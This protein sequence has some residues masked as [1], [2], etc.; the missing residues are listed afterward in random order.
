M[1]EFNMELIKEN[2]IEITKSIAEENGNYDADATK[3]CLFAMYQQIEQW[4]FSELDDFFEEGLGENKTILYDELWGVTVGYALIERYNLS[5][6]EYRNW[7]DKQEDKYFLLKLIGED[8]EKE[9]QLEACEDWQ[10]ILESLDS[11]KVLMNYTDIET[12][13]TLFGKPIILSEEAKSIADLFNELEGIKEYA[14]SILENGISKRCADYKQCSKN[15]VRVLEDSVGAAWIKCKKYLNQKKQPEEKIEYLKKQYFEKIEQIYSI[16]D[17][18]DNALNQLSEISGGKLENIVLEDKKRR[19]RTFAGGGLGIY[20][21]IAGMVGASVLNK[22]NDAWADACTRYSGKQLTEYL[23]G[24]AEEIY[25]GEET[26]KI[27]KEV[28]EASC[29]ELEMLCIDE[30]YPDSIENQEMADDMIE[31]VQEEFPEEI[32]DEQYRKIASHILFAFPLNTSSYEYVF[33]EFTDVREELLNIARIFHVKDKLKYLNG[34]VM[35][36]LKSKIITSDLV[37]SEKDENVVVFDSMQYCGEK[38]F[39]ELPIKFSFFNVNTSIVYYPP[40]SVA[41]RCT[42]IKNST[43]EIIDIWGGNQEDENF[44]KEAHENSAQ[45]LDRM[46]SWNGLKIKD[47]TQDVYIY[48]TD[49]EYRQIVRAERFLEERYYDIF[50]LVYSSRREFIC[51]CVGV[52]SAM[53]DKCEYYR[54][55]IEN[56]KIFK[57]VDSLETRQLFLSSFEI[58]KLAQKEKM[59][60]AFEYIEN[61]KDELNLE[62]MLSFRKRFKTLIYD[63]GTDIFDEYRGNNYNFYDYSAPSFVELPLKEGVWGNK[64]QYI[65]YF[66]RNIVVTDFYIIILDITGDYVKV[67]IEDICEIFPVSYYIVG[68]A[69]QLCFRMLNDENKIINVDEKHIEEFLFVC[70]VVN[71]ALEPLLPDNSVQ[72]YRE[73]QK[74]SQRNMAFCKNCGKIVVVK[75]ADSMVLRHV[76]CKK[77]G[78]GDDN[79]KRIL[80]DKNLVAIRTY[81][82]D[83]MESLEKEGYFTDEEE[84]AKKYD[85]KEISIQKNDKNDERGKLTDEIKESIKAGYKNIKKDNLLWYRILFRL[86]FNVY[87]KKECIINRYDY[88]LNSILLREFFDDINLKGQYV[89]YS[90]NGFVIT[91]QNLYIET[92]KS[93]YVFK[94]EDLVEIF[95]LKNLYGSECIGVCARS[96]N[97]KTKIYF[98]SYMIRYVQLFD[99]INIALEIK[100]SVNKMDVSRF[101][102]NPYTEN[103]QKII[104]CDHCKTWSHV[105]SDKG[106]IFYNVHCSRCYENLTLNKSYTAWVSKDLDV[107]KNKIRANIR[108]TF[109]ELIEEEKILDQEQGGILEYLQFLEEQE[110]GECISTEVNQSKANMLALGSGECSGNKVEDRIFCTHCGKQILKSAKFC[111]FCG[112]KVTYHK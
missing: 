9:Q 48:H 45:I 74:P 97:N 30:F 77:C 102:Q 13:N 68:N 20:G 29:R 57:K 53:G 31:L 79:I 95:P 111:N 101:Y 91:D 11:L 99:I 69:T 3:N 44:Q 52:D 33:E 83:R 78:A 105:C 16:K 106:L 39:V 34:R 42:F 93:S 73:L 82:K 36:R 62:F 81:L 72:Y 65:L 22:L 64:G 58:E 63:P 12:G 90:D 27:Y 41:Q 18:L 37:I 49:E 8:V 87:G 26:R 1:N 92:G 54:D 51:I 66:S 32:T 108:K 109:D 28:I 17:E 96:Q 110:R 71:I 35:G 70:D 85:I 67:S 38:Y 23:L 103:K 15:I 2:L 14:I 40:S 59:E 76:I 75:D 10:D 46:N 61:H 84:M 60:S 89:L 47:F 55:M 112:A 104:Y 5:L 107:K 56:I 19:S 43:K 100:D 25:L 7:V 86:C 21:S 80:E 98:D 24:K 88:Q 4:S 6:E 94:I 50:L